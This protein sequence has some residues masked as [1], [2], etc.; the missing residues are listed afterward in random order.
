VHLS[1][2]VLN[3]S[4]ELVVRERDNV[5]ISACHCLNESYTWGKT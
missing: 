3:A 5:E 2:L 1:T 4:T